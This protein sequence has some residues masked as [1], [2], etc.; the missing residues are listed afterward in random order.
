[1]PRKHTE[2]SVDRATW[3]DRNAEP[4]QH[5]QS[6]VKISSKGAG[7]LAD[8]Y[9]KLATPEDKTGKHLQLKSD[10][11]SVGSRWRPGPGKQLHGKASPGSK[12]S[13][14]RVAANKEL[15]GK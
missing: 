11:D 9:S 1:M 7:Q 15:R 14:V 3:Y 12:E 6:K 13:F 2:R 4:P 8:G 10:R 5:E